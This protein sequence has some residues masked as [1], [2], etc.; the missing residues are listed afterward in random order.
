VAFSRR[1]SQLVVPHT[2]PEQ[3][4]APTVPRRGRA[5]ED[6]HRRGRSPL[7]MRLRLR[8]A[9]LGTHRGVTSRLFLRGPACGPHI[10]LSTRAEPSRSLSDRK[11][12]T[13]R[14]P[15]GPNVYAGPIPIAWSSLSRVDRLAWLRVKTHRA[16]LVPGSWHLRVTCILPSLVVPAMVCGT[17][18][19]FVGLFVDVISYGRDAHEH[20]LARIWWTSAVDLGMT[21]LSLL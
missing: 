6:T 2:I 13:A 12:L 8:G 5:Q 14:P 10:G 18:P 4:C 19:F 21:F 17:P 15:K 20:K 9:A 7:A 16:G 1:P 3:W 11:A